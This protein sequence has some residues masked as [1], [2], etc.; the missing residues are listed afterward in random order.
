M[1]GVGEAGEDMGWRRCGVGR[2]RKASG[3][4][5]AWVGRIMGGKERGRGVG[6]GLR[7]WA[8]QGGSG[9]TQRAHQPGEWQCASWGVGGVEGV[10]VA[11]PSLHAAP[12][13]LTR[14]PA[15][16]SSLCR[17]ASCKGVS[18]RGVGGACV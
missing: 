12:P 16:A 6:R 18:C 15:P 2:G 4:W 13:S 5:W 10:S 11:R 14:S 8:R 1:V 9:T 3:G 17:V 7:A